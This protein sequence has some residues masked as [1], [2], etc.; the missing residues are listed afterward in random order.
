V[1]R[2]DLESKLRDRRV[3]FPRQIAMYLLRE[4]GGL[5]LTEIGTYFGGRDHTTVLHSCEKV[6]H[7]L[8]HNERVR[9]TVR[10]VR[11]ILAHSA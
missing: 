10:A 7:D 6:N 8:E 11:E 1:S 2:G 3:V 9:S 4:N 5:S